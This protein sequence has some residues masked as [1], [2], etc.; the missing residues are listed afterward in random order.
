MLPI[1]LLNQA[2]DPRLPG[3]LPLA[4]KPREACRLL[5]VGITRLYELIAAGELETFKDG[6]SRKITTRS[7]I[8]RVERLTASAKAPG[9]A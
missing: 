6:S 4:V 5:S 1:N 8:A 2:G 9:S 7:I 3:M